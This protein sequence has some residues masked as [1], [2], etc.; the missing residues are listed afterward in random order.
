MV[1]D[2]QIFSLYPSAKQK[3]LIAKVNKA[4]RD[5]GWLK[6]IFKQYQQTRADMN[7]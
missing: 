7:T 4:D 1:I 2:T 5:Y 6:D 3:A